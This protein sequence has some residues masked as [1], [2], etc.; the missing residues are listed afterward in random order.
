MLAGV[1]SHGSILYPSEYLSTALLVPTWSTVISVFL[2]TMLLIRFC[3]SWN[4]HPGF[5]YIHVSVSLF[6]KGASRGC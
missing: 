3:R 5:V 1:S 6:R 4:M 2:V